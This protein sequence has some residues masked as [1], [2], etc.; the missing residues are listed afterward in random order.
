MKTTI[1]GPAPAFL[2]MIAL[3]AVLPFYSYGN[4]VSV[5]AS[6]NAVCQFAVYPSHQAIYP[7][8]SNVSVLFMPQSLA[9]CSVASMPGSM[10]VYYKNGTVALNLTSNFYNITLHNT[11]YDFPA[12]FNSLSQG[13]YTASITLKETSNYTNSTSVSL[14]LLNPPNIMASNMVIGNVSYGATLPI[15]LRLFNNGSLSTNTITLHLKINGTANYSYSYKLGTIAPNQTVPVILSISNVTNTPGPYNAY[16]YASFSEYSRRFVS[17]TVHANYTVPSLPSK[18]AKIPVN[19]TAVPVVKPPYV[20]ITTFP[21]YSSIKYGTSSVSSLG[22]KNIINLSESIALS[23]NSSYSGLMSLSATSLSLN[24]NQTELVQVYAN[25]KTNKPGT[26]IVPISISV[27]LSN[28][29]YSSLKEYVSFTIYNTTN[30]TVAINYNVNLENDTSQALGTVTVTGASNA[31]LKNT[32]LLT[33][34]PKAEVSSANDI[35]AYGLPNR[36]EVVN[37]YYY[38]VWNISSIPASKEVIVYYS[39]S[40]PVSQA[41]LSDIQNVLYSPSS[42]PFSKLFKITSL[43]VPTLFTNTS[44]YV[45]V[46]A[47]YTGMLPST[48]SMYLVSSSGVR[49]INSSYTQ[50][51]APNQQLFHSFLIYSGSV[52]GTYFLYLYVSAAGATYNYSLPLLVERIAPTTT[53]P[54][55]VPPPVHETDYYEYGA[56]IAIIIII[57]AVAYATYKY[58]NRPRY[59]AK[60][61]KELSEIKEE[62]RGKKGRGA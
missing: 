61:T 48:L 6:I 39:I 13:N 9:N 62:V 36:L 51:I 26:Y 2:L 53:I 7:L 43:S 5:N 4:T 23:I 14:I 59:S 11:S 54:T 24:P 35:N 45:N 47:I 22:L 3:L 60:V 58:K 8:L 44:G 21:V 1:S 17:N 52:P 12:S 33:I 30:S 41:S 56:Y 37:N 31:T 10:H 28:G 19:R 27:T 50:S 20:E 16:V 55:V 38:I 32:T 29:T 49:A 40:N 42:I 46:S 18:S 15:S 34:I 57:A 25:G